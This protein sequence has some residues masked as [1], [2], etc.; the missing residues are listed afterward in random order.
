MSKIRLM[1]IDDSLFF[2]T[3]LT[4]KLGGN[5]AIEIVGSFG[6]PLEAPEF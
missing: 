3:F 1:I 6:D 2:R 5:P 4:H